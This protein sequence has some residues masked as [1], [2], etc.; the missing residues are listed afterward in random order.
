MFPNETD[1][2]ICIL[3]GRGNLTLMIYYYLLLTNLFHFGSVFSFFGRKGTCM[4]VRAVTQAD[5][6][7]ARNNQF[8]NLKGK[9]GL[10]SPAIDDVKNE[11]HHH[12]PTPA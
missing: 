8:R 3:A 7:Q 2:M 12:G 1:R 11:G 10:R 6:Q 5:G 9:C 4:F